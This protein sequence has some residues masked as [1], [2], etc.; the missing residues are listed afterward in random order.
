MP[1]RPS[2][3]PETRARARALRRQLTPA[4]ARLWTHL[5][6]S[7]LGGWKFR[8][9]F[10]FGLYILDFYCPAAQLAVELDGESH[11]APAT[12]EKDD[13]RDAFL[14]NHGIRVLRFENCLVFEASAWVLQQIRDA[15][16]GKAIEIRAA[17]RPGR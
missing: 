17:R 12:R 4:E 10:P 1:E 11:Q 16:E 3:S 8:R 13:R 2:S 9:Q 15:L 7:K 14:Q 5:S 6:G